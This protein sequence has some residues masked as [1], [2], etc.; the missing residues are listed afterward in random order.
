[1]RFLVT[2][3]GDTQVQAI[4]GAVLEEL[5]R[6]CPRAEIELVPIY[7]FHLKATYFERRISKLGLK[8]YKRLYHEKLTAEFMAKCQEFEP[9]FIL[10]LG[11]VVDFAP[12]LEFLSRYRVILWLWDSYRR[13]SGL[14]NLVRV[15]SEVFCFEYEDLAELR[16]QLSVPV[17]YLP[18]GA[19]AKIYSPAECERDVDI[20][21]VGAPRKERVKILEKV[22]ALALERNWS[23]KIVGPFLQERHFYKKIFFR[24]KNS[25]LVKCIDRDYTSP[26]ETAELYRRSKI[27]LNINTVEH[28]SL[29]PRTFE[30]CATRSFQLMNGGQ[31]AHGLMNLETDLVTFDSVEDLLAKIEFYLAHD[32]LREKIARAGYESTLKNCTLEKSVAKLCAASEIMRGAAV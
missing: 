1:M 31:A 29:S 18:L 32:E 5:K 3:P 11:G 8:N 24:F 7:D 13:F 27:C 22:C 9:D 21:F 14:I 19:D 6:F 26:N 15:S 16:G 30:I 23:V 4:A 25:H 12:M 2:T 28:H 20:S 10:V 17:E